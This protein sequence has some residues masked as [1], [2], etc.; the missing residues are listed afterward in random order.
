MDLLQPPLRIVPSQRLTKTAPTNRIEFYYL[1][2]IY[3]QL[4][5]F[6]VSAR[7]VLA[8]PFHRNNRNKETDHLSVPRY[9][10]IHIYVETRRSEVK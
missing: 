10:Y 6:V 7:N 5:K 4:V 1:L 8:A 9:I 2:R 3:R